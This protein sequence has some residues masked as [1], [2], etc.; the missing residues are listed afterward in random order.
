MH[1]KGNIKG[2]TIGFYYNLTNPEAQ[3]KSDD[4]LHFDGISETF[5]FGRNG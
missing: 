1:I 3:L 4:F 5:A 2:D